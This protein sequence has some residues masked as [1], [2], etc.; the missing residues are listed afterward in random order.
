MFARA[1]DAPVAAVS[2]VRV[3]GVG[4]GPAGGGGYKGADE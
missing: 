1:E 2:G 4:E 3:G